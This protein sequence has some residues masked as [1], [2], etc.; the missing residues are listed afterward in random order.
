[1]FD[2]KFFGD[3]VCVCM[4]EAWAP[5][6]STN[7]KQGQTQLTHRL[8]DFGYAIQYKLVATLVFIIICLQ[9]YICRLK[10]ILIIAV[11]F[12]RVVLLGYTQRQHGAKEKDGNQLHDLT[13]SLWEFQQEWGA[14]LDADFN[15]PQPFI[16][17]ASPPLSALAFQGPDW[18]PAAIHY[19]PCLKGTNDSA[20]LS[21]QISG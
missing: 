11:N 6:D 14:N 1:M 21:K 16:S 3:W 19:M 15:S 2:Y 13:I 4:C 9:S 17:S 20:G 10:Y 7:P 12:L 8:G 18:I 5:S